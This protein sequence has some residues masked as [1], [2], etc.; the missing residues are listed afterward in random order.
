MCISYGDQ[1][2]C[3]FYKECK[4]GDDCHRALTPEV[5]KKATKWS[6]GF[7]V[8]G[9]LISKFTDKQECFEEKGE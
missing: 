5:I 1:W 3:Q 8:E 7:G 6:K 9:A 4:H 2:F